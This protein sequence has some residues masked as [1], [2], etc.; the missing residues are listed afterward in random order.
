MDPIGWFIA[1]LHQMLGHDKAAAVAGQPPGDKSACVICAYERQPTA[2]NRQ[3]VV[4]ALA[5]ERE[6]S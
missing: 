3:R 6:P 4:D 1:T 2:E 5:P